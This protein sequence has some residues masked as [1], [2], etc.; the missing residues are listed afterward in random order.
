MSHIPNPQLT[1]KMIP[2]SQAGWDVI[3]AFAL[4]FNGFEYWGSFEACGEKAETA[5]KIYNNS[6][7]LPASLTLL[8]TCLFFEQ[9]RWRHYGYAPDEPAMRYIRAL[10]AA[11]AEH[12]RQGQRE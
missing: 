12:V 7:E 5:Q 9:R 3:G 11:I 1:L 2:N 8:R 10:V 6:A 4:N